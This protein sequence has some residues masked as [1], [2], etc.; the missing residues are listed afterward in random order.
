MENSQLPNERAYKN[1][2]I[3]QKGH[4]ILVSITS[5]VNFIFETDAET[6]DVI[7][8]NKAVLAAS[9]PVFK[10]MFYSD[11]KEEGDIKIVDVP[12]A[13]FNEFLQFFYDYQVKLTMDNISD[14]L[15]LI[16]KYDVGNGHKVCIDFLKDHLMLDDIIWGLHLSI[17]FRLDELMNFCKEKIELNYRAVFD[18]ITFNND[19]KIC[20]AN[21]R[22]SE[23]DWKA[24]L[25]QVFMTSQNVIRNMS[26]Q[27][28]NKQA[29]Y[30]INLAAA[31][32]SCSKVTNKEIIVFSLDNPMM[33]TDI[34]CSNIFSYN[35]KL[36][37]VISF[38]MTIERKPKVS[39]WYPDILYHGK[40]DIPMGQN[41]VKLTTP[42]LIEPHK[43]YAINFKSNVVDKLIYTKKSSVK[44]K[45]VK[46]AP[47]VNIS[48]LENND[49]TLVALLY[50]SHLS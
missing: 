31:E 33:L 47:N 16:D 22:L 12:S 26:E 15:Q 29:I 21:D 3:Y 37:D 7:S 41:C 4:E 9:S 30:L 11:L 10:A 35:D 34:V 27:L 32:N 2:F 28:Q 14:V 24:V 43:V 46:L 45:V 49:K 44:N 18:K 1:D 6:D 8:A 19:G 48:F 17:K 36:A 40:V 39:S 25:P 38:D 5:D 23:I 42:M 13:A 50:F 20:A